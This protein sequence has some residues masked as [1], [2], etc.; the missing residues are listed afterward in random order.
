MTE[1][2]KILIVDDRKE[3]L[4]ALRHILREVDAEVVEATSGNLALAATLDHDF[5]VAILDVMMPGMSG[6]EL[7]EHLRGDKKTQLTP[8]VFVTASFADERHMFKGY[9]AG[10][11]DYITKPCPPE[12]LQGKVNVFLEMDRYRRELREHRDHLESLVAD[13]TAELQERVKELKCL[14]AISSLVAEPCKSIDEAMQ[15]AVDMIPAGLQHPD[16]ACA[17]ILLEG[18]EFATA[19]FRE[20]ARREA[21]DIVISGEKSGAVEVCFIEA[22]P[23]FDKSPFLEEERN[24]VNDIARQLGVM[25]HRERARESVKESEERY[26]ALVEDMPT[27]VCRFL[28]NGTLTFVSGEYCKYFSRTE[29]ELTGQDFFQFIPEEDRGYVSEQFL[30]LSPE[31]PEVT[32]EHRVITADGST[33]WQEWTDRLLSGKEGLREYQAVGLDITARKE[34][35]E[36]LHETQEQLRQAQKLEAIGQLAGGIAH[37]FN[38]MLSAIIGYSDLILTGLKE[39]D[40]LYSDMENIKSCA[41]RSAALTRQLLAFSRKQALQPRVL[42]LNTIVSDMDRMLR[43][44]IGEHIELVSRPAEGLWQVK[45]DPGQI[46]QVIM[47]L[48]VN[49]RDAMPDGGKLTVE[50]A[51]VELD[52]EYARTHVSAKPGPHVMI[53]VTDTGCGMDK[54][55]LSRIF[56]PFFTTKESGKGTGLGLSTAYGIVKQSGGNIWVYSEPEKGTTFKV[57]LPR[58]EGVP[59]EKVRAKTVAP[60]RGTETVLVVEDEDAV[61]ELVARILSVHG[62]KVLEAPN[63]GEALVICE[64]H[65]N[66]DLLITDVVMP[67]MGGRELAER[68][69]KMRPG[70]K[71]LYTSGYTDN[72][73]VH[74]GVLDA[75]T[76]FIQKPYTVS[77][78]LAKV[79][80]VLELADGPKDGVRDC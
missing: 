44:L 33:R 62:Y 53:A 50:S 40:P 32:Y 79:R 26:R 64:K 25:I 47:N 39:E 72:A 28:E 1:R 16:I 43:R 73:I 80:E 76:P 60:N 4:V 68:V 59:D 21:A 52:E 66:I 29:D 65:G 46:E 42:D 22:P 24:L 12:V 13:R 35:E 14:Y 3:N 8:I 18:R 48:A 20:T 45:A 15:T 56:E 17:R 38:N 78:L 37:D 58:V 36:E 54:E 30:S 49:A 71:V 5:A 19:N 55:T 6:Y 75:G 2:Q 7:A 63:G 67:N 61:R 41:D 74:Q 77:A 34:A 69:G 11:I 23:G 27:L 51:N 70:V 31:N 10:G 57:Y 9:E